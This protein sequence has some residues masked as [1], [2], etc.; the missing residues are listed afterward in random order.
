MVCTQN[1]APSDGLMFAHAFL[2]FGP[3]DKQVYGLWQGD[4][5]FKDAISISN[6]NVSAFANPKGLNVQC[7]LYC[8]DEAKVGCAERIAQAGTGGHQRTYVAG[9]SNLWVRLVLQE[10]GI[11]QWTG[12]DIVFPAP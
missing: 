10:A 6:W 9:E 8:D 5:L 3:D 7:R 12:Y 11:S 1:V 2:V 4:I